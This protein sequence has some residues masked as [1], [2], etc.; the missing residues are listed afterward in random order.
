MEFQ[1]KTPTVDEVS[2]KHN[3]SET[4]DFMMTFILIR[5]S[6]EINLAL[7][8]I[9]SLSLIKDPPQLLR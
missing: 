8:W 2:N 3:L 5:G 1:D 4:E 6:L 9:R 7:A